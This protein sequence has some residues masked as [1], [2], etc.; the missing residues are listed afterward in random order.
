M[1]REK[2][3]S[4]ISKMFAKK[5]DAPDS[6]AKMG[7][8]DRLFFG[9]DDDDDDVPAGKREGAG[10]LDDEPDRAETDFYN[11][12]KYVG[13]VANGK[14]HGH[15]VYYYDSGDKCAA[16]THKLRQPIE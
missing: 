10:L 2:R 3:P 15:G 16:A 1:P 14:R 11:G 7:H 9:N 13:D 12:D 8:V 6:A 4:F 5:P